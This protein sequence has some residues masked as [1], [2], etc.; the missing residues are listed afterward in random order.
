MLSNSTYEFSGLPGPYEPIGQLVFH[1]IAPK[2]VN[3][4]LITPHS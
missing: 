4:V 2:D 3:R 1:V